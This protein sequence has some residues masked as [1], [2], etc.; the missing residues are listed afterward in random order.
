MQR[1]NTQYPF[2]SFG[3][4]VEKISSFYIGL[5]KA[6]PHSHKSLGKGWGLRLWAVVKDLKYNNNNEV[7]NNK[8]KYQN[9]PLSLSSYSW[10]FRWSWVSCHSGDLGMERQTIGWDLLGCFISTTRALTGA[11]CTGLQKFPGASGQCYSTWQ[12][13]LCW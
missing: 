13:F 12:F 11:L 1:E 9:S 8:I 5:C 3:V 4:L 2:Q 7:P 6:N 10:L